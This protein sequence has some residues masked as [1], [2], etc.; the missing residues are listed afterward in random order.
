[1]L[2]RGIKS[3]LDELAATFERYRPAIDRAAA[4][5]DS[6][7]ARLA[8]RIP[9]GPSRKGAPRREPNQF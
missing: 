4:L 1:M 7:A 8:A 3:T 6:P 9:R 2:L 5:A